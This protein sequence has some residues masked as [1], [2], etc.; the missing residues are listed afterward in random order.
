MKKKII[1]LLF[2]LALIFAAN[3]CSKKQEAPT[4]SPTNA[5]QTELKPDIVSE[6]KPSSVAPPAKFRK[7]FLGTLDGKINIQMELNRDGKQLFGS[8]FYENVR[9]YIDLSGAIETDNS[10]KITESTDGKDTG[11]FKGRLSGEEINGV[12][13]LR[14]EGTWSNTKGDK[15]MPFSLREQTFTLSNGLKLISKSIKDESKKEHYELEATY[16]QIA[17]ASDARIEG[18]NKLVANFVNDTVSNFKKDAPESFDT[19]NPDATPSGL[20][21]NHVVVL[22]NDGLISV[23]LNVSNYASGAAHPNHFSQ[24]FNYDLKNGQEIKLSDIFKPGANY[25]QALSNY[26]IKNL[27]ARLK[28]TDMA[29][30]SMIKDGASAD[31]ENFTSWNITPK[32]LLF[33]FDPYQVAAYAAGSQEILIPYATLK[34]ILKTDSPVGQM[35]LLENLSK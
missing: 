15:Q 22:A 1:A 11:V 33:T 4:S 14:F 18:F 30:D 9:Q 31:A 16:P 6:T 24:T 12:A 20:F 25:L 23:S 35:M 19:E 2:T 26:A 3:A 28:K 21:I 32:G 17:G 7:I 8:Y 10:C 13:T 5:G 29:D 27:T 34:D